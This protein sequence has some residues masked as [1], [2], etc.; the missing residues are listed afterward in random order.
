MN[1]N[2]NLDAHLNVPGFLGAM[3]GAL[4]RWLLAQK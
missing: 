1:T 3:G 4:V 2:V